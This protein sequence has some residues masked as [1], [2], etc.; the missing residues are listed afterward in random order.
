MHPQK[1]RISFIDGFLGSRK[2]MAAAQIGRHFPD[3][4]IFLE[5]HPN[6]PLRVGAPDEIGFVARPKSY[7]KRTNTLIE[8]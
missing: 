8:W 3:D 5:S 6:H 2:S 7:E 4:R 1:L